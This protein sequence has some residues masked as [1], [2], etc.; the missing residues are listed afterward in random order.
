MLFD[1][2]RLWLYLSP[3]L[4]IYLMQKLWLRVPLEKVEPADDGAMDDNYDHSVSDTCP[5][6]SGFHYLKVRLFT[7]FQIE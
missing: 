7:L 5:F 2:F 6:L 1:V 3:V 4:M